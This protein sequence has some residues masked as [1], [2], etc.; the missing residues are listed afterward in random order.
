MQNRLVRLVCV[1]LQSLIR[2]DIVK[3]ETARPSVRWG[4]TCSSVQDLFIEVQSFCIEFSR[5][6]EAAGLYRLLATLRSGEPLPPEIAEQ[7]A[8]CGILTSA[9]VEDTA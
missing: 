1:F 8:G 2:H 5:I 4:L 9:I 3:G 7:L 6:R